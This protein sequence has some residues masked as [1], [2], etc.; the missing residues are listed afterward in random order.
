MNDFDLNQQTSI[1]KECY[2][3]QSKSMLKMIPKS[4]HL[5]NLEKNIKITIPMLGRPIPKLKD[6]QRLPG[7]QYSPLEDIQNFS[8]FFGFSCN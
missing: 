4:I 6:R 8:P 2:V 3:D 5:T 7:V 1:T